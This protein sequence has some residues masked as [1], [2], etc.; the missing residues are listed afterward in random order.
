LGLTTH[1]TVFILL[2]AVFRRISLQ[3]TRNDTDATES[4]QQAEKVEEEEEKKK[5]KTK[6]AIITE[7]NQKY[8][9]N[10]KAIVYVVIETKG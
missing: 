2:R 7:T 9:F 3:V 1:R 5:W 10:R 6:R 4:L 8:R